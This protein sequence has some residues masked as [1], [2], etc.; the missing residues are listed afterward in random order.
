MS[1]LSA[2]KGLEIYID[3]WTGLLEGVLVAARAQAKNSGTKGQLRVLWPT[4]RRRCRASLQRVPAPTLNR[5]RN[6]H[7]QSWVSVFQWPQAHTSTRQYCKMNDLILAYLSLEPRAVSRR[8]PKV[9]PE[10]P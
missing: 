5:C 3:A 10:Y 7:T 6:P 9:S 2:P 1:C 4:H 8:A